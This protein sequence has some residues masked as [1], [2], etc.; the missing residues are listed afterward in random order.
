MLIFAWLGK[1][2]LGGGLAGITAQL[3]E[4]YKQRIDAQ[5]EQERIAADERVKTLEAQ[6]DVLVAE[7]ASGGFAAWIRPLFALPFVIYIWKLIVWDKVLALG[8][9]DPL[10]PELSDI[11]L[12][13]ITA[14]FIGRTAEKVARIAKR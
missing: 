6:R 12:L 13:V 5:T 2:L 8:A 11:M 14:Y 4:A 9:T 1:W 7:T 10:S 3:A